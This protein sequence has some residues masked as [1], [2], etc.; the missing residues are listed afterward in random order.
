[1]NKIEMPYMDK[2]EVILTLSCMKDS[3]VLRENEIVVELLKKGEEEIITKLFNKC[4]K[5][6]RILYTWKNAIVVLL[7]RR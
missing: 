5:E 3:R 4:L 7:Y 6:G 2:A 1:M